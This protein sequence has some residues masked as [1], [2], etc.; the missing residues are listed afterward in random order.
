MKR[1]IFAMAI[2]LSAFAFTSCEEDKYGY[3]NRVAFSAR[4]G[5]EDVDGDD[6]IY[7]LSIADYDGNEKQAE[8]EVIMVV[9]YDWLTASAVKN[10]TEIKLIAEPNTTGKRRKLYVYG[11]VHNKVIDITVIQDK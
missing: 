4:G 7:T 6:P 5:T 9:N 10:S 11:M 8:G 1:M 2:L 3:D